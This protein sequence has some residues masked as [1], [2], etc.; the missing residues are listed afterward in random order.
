MKRLRSSIL[1]AVT[2]LLPVAASGQMPNPSLS[3]AEFVGTA[4]MQSNASNATLPDART[5]LGLGIPVSVIDKGAKHD[6]LT[7]PD[8]V[9]T[10]GTTA[11][12]SASATFTAADIGKLIQIDGASGVGSAPLATTIAAYVSAHAVTL[13]VPATATTP[14]SYF[15]GATVVTNQGTG[16]YVPGDLIT[17]TGGTSSIGAVATVQDTLVTATTINAGGTA[18]TAGACVVQGTTGAGTLFQQNVTIAAGAISAVGTF[19]NA[20]HYFTKPTSLAAE[21]ITN[22]PGYNCAPTGATLVLTMGVE[23]VYV[24]TSGNYSVTPTNPAATGAGSISG[25]T[26][27]TL[28]VIWNATGRFVYGSDD[29]AAFVSA[30]NQAATNY[31][32]GSPAYVFAPAGNYL[33]DASALP[34]MGSGLGVRGE[35]TNKTNFIIGANYSGDLFSWFGAWLASSGQ[36]NGNISMVSANKAGPKATGFSV[37]GNRLATATQNALV[38]YDR[39]DE[40]VI[41]DVDVSYLNGRCLYSGVIKTDVAAYMRESRL[42]KLR[43]FNVGAVGS[44]V[45]EFNSQG[46]G[47]ASNAIDIGEL[48]IYAPYGT[49]LLIRN[50]SVNAV[51][52]IRISKLRVEGL[53]YNSANIAADLVVIGDAVQTGIVNNIYLDQI[54]LVDPY[55]GQAA[56]RLTAPTTATQPYFIDVVGV[57]EGGTPAGFGVKIDAGRALSFKLSQINTWNTNFSVASS[58]TV[59]API[60][61]DMLG[62]ASLL[63]YNLDSTTGA[64][65]LTTMRKTGAPTNQTPSVTGAVTADIP[66]STSLGGNTRG[67]GAVDLQRDRI[68][69]TQVASGLDSVSIGGLGNTA[70]GIRA[71]SLGGFKNLATGTTTVVSGNLASDHGSIGG[72]FNGGAGCE[73][74]SLSGGCQ[75]GVFVLGN[76][77]ASASAVRLTSNA[78]AAGAANC[79][80]IPAGTV[81]QTAIKISVHDRN[82]HDYASWNAINGTLARGTGNA[83]YAGA[84]TVAAVPDN[85]SGGLTTATLIVSADA[86]NQCLNIS[87][88]PPGGN[89]D[90]IDVT[91]RIDTTEVQ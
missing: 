82:T 20:G 48:D 46:T 87:F 76:T 53:E 63:T 79:V 77:I 25:A 12:S 67:V 65:V 55:A 6:A 26:G 74:F 45:V 34:T 72:F 42:G 50:N 81:Y 57:I 33:I 10:T 90:T 68:A 52:G 9:I 13:T 56:L 60:V 35:G 29:S 15:A 40:V 39:N 69:N 84:G 83:S 38:L 7:F 91:A 86:T 31:A 85:A 43:C 17:I 28:S 27:T 22:A 37:W 19:V 51:R 66:D 11:F 64:N 23:T 59:G 36:F 58:T 61:L 5:N 30:I 8:G 47:D 89:T 54:G 71:T 80:N 88:T 1:V 3:G 4:G 73:T 18:G 78:A 16:S 21:P 41:D 49:G 70:S 24:G 75:W 14:L 44:P 62:G 32:A 2:L